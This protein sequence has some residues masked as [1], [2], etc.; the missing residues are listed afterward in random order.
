MKRSLGFLNRF[1]PKTPG[2]GAE[3]FVHVVT[4][5]IGVWLSIR[6]G[7]IVVLQDHYLSDPGF[8]LLNTFPYAPESW[9][10]VTLGL[11]GLV[12]ASVMY[13]QRRVLEVCALAAATS[14]AVIGSVLAASFYGGNMP[15]AYASVSWF[16]L[17]A[18]F[19]AR[20]IASSRWGV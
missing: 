14:C 20:F 1:L 12:L 8:R 7:I 18:L 3:W 13:R 5:A 19:L 4:A 6:G 11:G 16:G 2:E 17:G 15:S 10:W 9:G